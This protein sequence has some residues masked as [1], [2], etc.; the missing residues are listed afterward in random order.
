[1][2]LFDLVYCFFACIKIRTK[3]KK[4]IFVGLGF[5]M[6]NWSGRT[7]EI[8]MALELPNC[9]RRKREKQWRV[10]GYLGPPSGGLSRENPVTEEEEKMMLFK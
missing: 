7:N 1:L 5:L 8:F 2:L 6:M 9:R 4:L 10:T 3:K